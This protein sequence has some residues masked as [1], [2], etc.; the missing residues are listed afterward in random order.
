MDIG[1]AGIQAVPAVPAQAPRD[2]CVHQ[3]AE[4]GNAH[5]YIAFHRWALTQG[6]RRFQQDGEGDHDQRGGVGEGGENGNAVVAERLARR[7][8]PLP[9]PDSIRRQPQRQRIAG[10]MPRV[11]KQRQRV[12]P[13]SK[14]GFHGHKSQCQPQRKPKPA[15]ARRP[16]C[17]SS[18]TDIIPRSERAEASS[19]GVTQ[20]FIR[21]LPPHLLLRRRIKRGE[22]PLCPFY[23]CPLLGAGISSFHH[24]GSAPAVHYIKHG[25]LFGNFGHAN[26][27]WRGDEKAV[28]PGLCA[29]GFQCLE[30]L[31]AQVV[32]HDFGQIMAA[33]ADA[34]PDA[35]RLLRRR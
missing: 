29:E 1:G 6:L 3:H 18:H 26:R 22:C 28:G 33:L 31:F 9:H 23:F 21:A 10:I 25:R 17:M 24:G 32:I 2:D 27:L 12:R 20:D 16:M 15:P 11:R 34:G 30:M 35:L 13:V 8:G 5:H 4:G 7:R 19:T 14:P